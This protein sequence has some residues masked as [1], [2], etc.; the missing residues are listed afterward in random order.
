MPKKEPSPS[1]SSTPN[2]G[3]HGGPKPNSMLIPTAEI[4]VA[5][6]VWLPDGAYSFS[7]ENVKDLYYLH[8]TE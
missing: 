5:F 7:C 6:A 4:N 8:T 3:N 1:Q 2:T